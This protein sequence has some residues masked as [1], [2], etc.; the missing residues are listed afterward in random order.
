MRWLVAVA[1]LVAGATGARADDFSGRAT[2]GYSQVR[3]EL[4][5]S[6]PRRPRH[7]RSSASWSASSASW[8]E[9]SMR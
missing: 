5:P 2:A 6:K 8:T 4:R 9:P 3:S 7:A 1:L